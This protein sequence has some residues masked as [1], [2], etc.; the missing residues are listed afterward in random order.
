MLDENF[1]IHEYLEQHRNK[2]LLRFITCGS[3][4][5]G[6]STLIGRL[7]FDTKQVFEDQLAAV[8]RD[9][10]KYGTTGEAPD[11]ALLVDGLQAEREQGITIDVAYRY[12]TTE[13]RKFIIADTPGHEQYTRNM[14]TGASTADLAIVLV[15]AR[16]GLQVQTRRHSY[17]VHL[18]GIRHVVVAVNKMDAVD[19]DRGVFDEIRDDYA[20]FAN[21]LGIE[22]FECVPV[23]A[24]N[25]ANVTRRSDEMDWYDGPTVL[26]L[27]ENTEVHAHEADRPLRFPV[28][29]V[30]RTRSD[31]R[32][33][34]GTLVSGEI[35]VGD[36]LVALPSGR[37]SKV[38]EIIRYEGAQQRASAGEAITL[39]L[40]DEIDVSRGDVLV[41][42]D[43]LPRV[44]ELF[45]ARVVWM[46]DRPLLPGRQYNLKLATSEVPATPETIHH[47][48]DVNTLEHHPADELELNEIGYCRIRTSRALAFDGY[49]AAIVPATAAPKQLGDP[50]FAEL[51]AY[52]ARLCPGKGRYPAVPWNAADGWTRAEMEQFD[53][54]SLDQILFDPD[55]R[56]GLPD[57]LRPPKGLGSLVRDAVITSLRVESLS[58]DEVS[59]YVGL[60]FLVG[61]LYGVLVTFPGGN[62]YVSNRLNEV[63]EQRDGFRC[64]RGAQ[65]VS[66][67]SDEAGGYRVV[68]RRD[69][70]THTIKAGSVVWAAPKHAAVSAIPE[71]P[72]GQREAMAEIEYGD[73]AIANVILKEPIW[74][75]LFGGYVIDGEG[76]PDAPWNWCRAGACIVA[77]WQDT[78]TSHPAGV[79]T[80][81]KPVARRKDQ[82]RM[83]AAGF[84]E[85]QRSVHDEVSQMLSAAGASPDLI[86]DIRI[87]QWP[88]GLVSPRRG[89]MKA[90]LFLRAGAP[91]GGVTFA[92]QDTYGVGNLETAI[93]AGLDAADHLMADASRAAGTTARASAMA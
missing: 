41:R 19:Y 42:V 62:G 73:Y 88:K 59:G 72:P 11:L 7:L 24:L 20:A 83:A 9:S 70:R 12:F 56:A 17:L 76:D 13:K 66:V 77:N 68:F 47:R 25:G 92:N 90:D 58:I 35:T 32:G 86:T 8:G 15:D 23:C 1:D 80:L 40:T 65:V 34:C 55:I 31:F 5:D 87:W 37:R 61:Y 54:L 57:D 74:A 89:Q 84:A 81:L 53:S 91:W 4:D 78:T 82:G 51:Y 38:A 52:L 67:L 39:T 36:E 28:Q 48:I 2:E 50:L 21:R 10:R 14:V 6:K 18:L 93:K 43:A 45:D 29:Y 33:F 22:H 27:L 60:H 63:L 64:E 3:V 26:D 46:S 75:D 16:N 30:N 85:M 71:L 44:S 69:G 49:G 79:L